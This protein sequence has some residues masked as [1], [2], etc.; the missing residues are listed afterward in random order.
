[1]QTEVLLFSA[2]LTAAA[3]W[4]FWRAHLIWNRD[5]LDLV[6]L[7]KKPLAGAERMK[8][9]FAV[10]PM[11]LGWAALAAAATMAATNTTAPWLLIYFVAN[12]LILGWHSLLVRGLEIYAA[13]AS[14]V[15]N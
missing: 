7:G 4:L 1:M 3:A 2:L 12:A 6:R 9:R 10:V 11:L 5:R 8:G 14:K 13:G 15:A